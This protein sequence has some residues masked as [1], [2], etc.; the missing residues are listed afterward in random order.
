MCQ[1]VDTLA[2][3]V[4]LQFLALVIQVLELT[5]K[6]SKQSMPI[7]ELPFRDTRAL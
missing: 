6:A 3:K 7:Q 1:K 5:G 2:D 4:D